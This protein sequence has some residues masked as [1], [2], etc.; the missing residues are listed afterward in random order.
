M[1]TVVAR[2]MVA[3]VMDAMTTMVVVAVVMRIV[4]VGC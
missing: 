4:G 1:V 2:V 3:G